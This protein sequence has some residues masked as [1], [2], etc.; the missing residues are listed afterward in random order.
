[1]IILQCRAR[2]DPATKGWYVPAIS[3][4]DIYERLLALQP[5][6]QGARRIWLNETAPASFWPFAKEFL[7]SN[8]AA[9]Q[10]RC[11]YT[12]ARKSNQW[13]GRGIAFETG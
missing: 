7:G 13:A 3:R 1:M 11:K 12:I 10:A 6:C 5:R 8:G 4:D 2:W 9:V